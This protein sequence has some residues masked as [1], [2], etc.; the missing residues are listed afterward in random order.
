VSTRCSHDRPTFL[1]MTELT[2]EEHSWCS[3][4]EQQSSAAEGGR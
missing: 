4:D 1:K 3:N 2:T